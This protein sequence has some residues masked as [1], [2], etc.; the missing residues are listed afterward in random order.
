MWICPK[1]LETNK[2]RLRKIELVRILHVSEPATI[3]RH[4]ECHQGLRPYTWLQESEDQKLLIDRAI[5]EDKPLCLMYSDGSA[6]HTQ[7]S[8]GWIVGV[9]VGKDRKW[10]EIA[11]GGGVEKVSS[12]PA[13]KITSARTEALGVLRG[14]QYT[15]KVWPGA[16]EIRLDN[17]TVVQR[18]N[19]LSDNKRNGGTM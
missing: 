16:I 14:K 10:H 13:R 7:G 3:E 9:E 17:T 19:R 4:I 18:H 5:A 12:N 1:C 6:K 8:Y 15:D 2:T 11:R